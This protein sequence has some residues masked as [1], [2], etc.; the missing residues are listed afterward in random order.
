MPYVPDYPQLFY[1]TPNV[2]A[3]MAK[4]PYAAEARRLADEYISAAYGDRQDWTRPYA[5]EAA[6][7]SLAGGWTPAVEREARAGIAQGVRDILG[8]LAPLRVSPERRAELQ[9]RVGAPAYGAALGGMY[10]TQAKMKMQGAGQAMQGLAPWA[11]AEDPY[12]QER[13]KLTG[14]ILS[15]MAP[16]S[17][18]WGQAS[19]FGSLPGGFGR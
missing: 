4:L 1:Q 15:R 6:Q 12:M 10:A 5:E 18:P 9:A 14:S 7:T 11:N 17:L 16:Q 8:G 13:A 2:N 3:M 19:G